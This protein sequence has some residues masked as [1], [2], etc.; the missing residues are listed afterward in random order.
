MNTLEAIAVKIVQA[1]RITVL[2]GAG[3]STASGIPDFRSR[4]GLYDN[5]LPMEHILSRSYFNTNPREFWQYFR[6]TFELDKISSRLPNKGHLFLKELEDMG[7]EVTILTQNV[8]GLHRLAGNTHVIELHGSIFNAIC[9]SCKK[10]YEMT[11]VLHENMPLCST[12]GAV[13]KPGVVLFEEGVLHMGDAYAAVCETDL[14]IVMGSS[15]EVY[16]VNTLPSYTV[17]AKNITTILI[18]RE[19]TR[20]DS[21]F[22]YVWNG[23]INECINKLM[24][25]S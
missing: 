1:A 19:P 20:M 5:G 15:L 22:Q 3:I 17:N 14:F 9:S 12:D 16:P 21:L 24:T 8:D 2:T 25:T 6:S 13:L 7:K 18:N 4:G 11:D 23:D 10:R